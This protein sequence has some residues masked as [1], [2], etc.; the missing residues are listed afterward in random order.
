MA[1]QPK[2]P[3]SYRATIRAIVI[4]LFVIAAVIIAVT[5]ISYIPSAVNGGIGSVCGLLFAGLL[6]GSVLLDRWFKAQ[7]RLK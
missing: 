7:R 4:V 2:P 1:Q 3:Y 6:I 5:F